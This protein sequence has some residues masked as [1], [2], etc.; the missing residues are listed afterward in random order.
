LPQGYQIKVGGKIDDIEEMYKGLI[1]II[2]LSIFLVYVILASQYES[3]IYPLIILT[4]SPL[5]LVGSFMAMFLFGQ[6]YNLMSIVGIIIML[7]ALD[8][9]AVIAV[10]MITSNRRNGMPLTD[11]IVYGMQKRFRAIVMTTLTSI[12]GMIPLVLGFGTGLELAAA[13][14]YP[15]IGGLIGSTIF[16][17]FLIPVLYKYFDKISN[18]A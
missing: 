18:V 13:I 14:S 5:A 3:I 17:M 16:T 6:S 9:D 11:A 15:V 2:I 8:N 1:V 12:I 7:G 4:T 10:D